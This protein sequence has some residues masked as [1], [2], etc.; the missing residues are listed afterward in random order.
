MSWQK[1]FIR[2]YGK[3][4]IMTDKQNQLLDKMIRGEV[5]LWTIDENKRVYV[6]IVSDRYV[7]ITG[8]K[9]KDWDDYEAAW[10]VY[11]NVPLVKALG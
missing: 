1:L 5:Q 2:R 8:P 3:R 9:K 11:Q 4:Y 6:E 7:H 10:E